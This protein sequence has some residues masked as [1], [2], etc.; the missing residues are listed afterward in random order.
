V[1]LA[2]ADP[3]R[4]ELNRSS[5]PCSLPLMAD[6]LSGDDLLVLRLLGPDVVEP[7]TEQ[8]PTAQP[9]AQ[10]NPRVNSVRYHSDGGILRMVITFTV[11]GS[12]RPSSRLRWAERSTM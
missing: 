8:P 11:G 2:V 3:A 6:H 12:S 9:S 1:V 7:T 5:R 10:A 4:S